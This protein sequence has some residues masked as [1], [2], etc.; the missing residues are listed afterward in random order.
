MSKMFSK[1]GWIIVAVLCLSLVVFP[2]CTGDGGGSEPIPYLHDGQFIQQTIGE[3]D[4]LDPAWGYDTASG[5][6]T[7]YIYDTLLSYDQESTTDF[8]TGLATNWTEVSTTAMKFHIASGITFHEGGNLTAEDVEYTFERALVQDRAGGPTWMFNY[9]LL[10][11]FRTRS[12]GNITVTGAEID[13]A[14]EI[15]DTDWVQFN[16]AFEFP[17][18]Q[19]KQILV[20]S[21]GSILDKEWC[22]AN[23]EWD[24]DLSGE[25]WKAYNNPDKQDSYLY[26]HANGTG[27]WKLDL[28]EAGEY[29]RLIANDDYWRGAPP[30]D[31]VITQWV[32]EWSSRKL[33]LLNGDADHVYV[34][35][36]YIGELLDIDDLL[37]ISALPEL[38]NDCL[39]FNMNIDPESD[40][41]GSGMLDGE[42]IPSD[43]FTDIHVRKGFSLAFDYDT[44]L[45]D[46]L[47]GE[48]TMLGSPLVNGL[49]GYDPDLPKYEQDLVE[50]AAELDLAWGGNL[51]SLGFKFTMVYNSGNIP[52]KTA[53]EILAEALYSI[54]PLY[55]VSILPMAWPT[56]LD[57][58]FTETETSKGPLPLFQIG[59]I[60]D[61]PDADNFITPFMFSEGDFA[62]FQDYGSPTVDA[63]IEAARFMANGPARDAAY[64]DI[65]NAYHDDP[66][67]IMLAQPLGRRF[68]TKYISGFYFNPTIPGTP[69]PLY[70][71]SKSES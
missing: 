15:V 38:S 65:H 39:F 57:N 33:T 71:M 4:S 37:K 47:L 11:K 18:I 17:A 66:G 7:D 6:Q 20:Q 22:V 29:I 41:I 45:A 48:G 21:W 49:A 10:G 64:A 13:A 59:W 46:A 44:Y 40:L 56:I 70:E 35:R 69:G 27:P 53:C 14:V 58:I 52:R 30:F 50:A 3:V 19:W 9:P 2:A 54:N 61:Y 34:P 36:A 67:G 43:F 63:M 26:N 32:D 25:G 51:T 55:Q 62:Y 31:T 1:M 68:F 42:G 12:A 5:E 23:G 28:W 60:A 8:I 24:G 16:F